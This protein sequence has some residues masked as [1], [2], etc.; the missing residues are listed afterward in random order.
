MGIDSQTRFIIDSS[1][2]YSNQDNQ[3]VLFIGY[4]SLI[5]D[6]D[7]FDDK[8][9]EKRFKKWEC[10]DI[11]NNQKCIT[12]DFTR[13]SLNKVFDVVIDHGSS[14]HFYDPWSGIINILSHIKIGGMGMHFLSFDGYGGFGYYQMGP[15]IFIDLERAGVIGIVNIY[16]FTEGDMGSVYQVDKH[17]IGEFSFGTRAR[18]AVVYKKISGMEERVVGFYQEEFNEKQNLVY[19]LNPRKYRNKLNAVLSIL[20]E[21]F[22]ERVPPWKRNNKFLKRI[23]IKDDK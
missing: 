2:N 18:F 14:Q 16:F 11:S 8:Y 4:P 19:K 7:N 15:N 1:I 5:D 22:L 13:E 12:K 9:L 20:Y 3:E 23:S 10:V 6:E 17:N 21:V